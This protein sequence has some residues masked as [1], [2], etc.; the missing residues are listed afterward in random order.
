MPTAQRRSFIAFGRW[1]PAGPSTKRFVFVVYVKQ[2]LGGKFLDEKISDAK[3][4]HET[5][6]GR[7]IFGRTNFRPKNKSSEKISVRI[8]FRAKF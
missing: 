7:Q 8:F 6:P 4:S 5:T 1:A 3:F 2:I